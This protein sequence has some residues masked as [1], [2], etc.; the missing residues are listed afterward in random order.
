MATRTEILRIDT[1]ARPKRLPAEYR[2]DRRSVYWVEREPLRCGPDGHTVVA[3]TPRVIE[4]SR[5]KTVVG[6]WRP[7]RPTPIW[8]VASGA[9]SAQPSSRITQLS[10]HRNPHNSYLFDRDP[11]WDVTDEAAQA[12]ASERLEQL[13]TPKTREERFSNFDP[14]WGYTYPVSENAQRSRC[15]ERLE[16]LAQHKGYHKEFKDERPI[17]WEVSQEA[18]EAIASLRLQQLARPRSRTM[19]KDDYDPYKVSP[20]AKKTRATPRLEELCLPIPRKVRQ[21]KALGT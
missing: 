12:R 10:Q 8:P 18:I 5:H 15:T 21:K 20:S 3:A 1:L 13:A 4:L 16:S 7:H 19:I 9:M 11:M 17:Q 14:F 2:D 6:A